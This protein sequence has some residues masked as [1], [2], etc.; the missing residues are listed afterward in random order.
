L[1]ISQPLFHRFPRVVFDYLSAMSG[2]HFSA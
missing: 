1:W 2:F